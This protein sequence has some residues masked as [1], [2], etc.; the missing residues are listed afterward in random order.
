MSVCEKSIDQKR[1]TNNESKNNQRNKY[2]GADQ[3]RSWQQVRQEKH[4]ENGQIL[5]RS[6]GIGTALLNIL[7]YDKRQGCGSD[8]RT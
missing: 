7:D 8:M 5:I 3:G 2:M 1:R 4:S 6:E